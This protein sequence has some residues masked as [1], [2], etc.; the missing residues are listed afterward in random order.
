MRGRGRPQLGHSV[1]LPKPG[2]QV[3]TR[4]R[5]REKRESDARRRAA[6][7]WML[8]EA[9]TSYGAIMWAAGALYLAW[10]SRSISAT[11]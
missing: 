9:G 2:E 8:R 10:P 3:G 7:F 5:A 4:A 11:C 6:R 1:P